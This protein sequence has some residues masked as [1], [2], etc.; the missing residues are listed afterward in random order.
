M[1]TLIQEPITNLFHKWKTHLP[2]T[3]AKHSGSLIC[4]EQIKKVFSTST[5]LQKCKIRALLIGLQAFPMAHSLAHALHCFIPP[6]SSH[7]SIHLCSLALCG[8]S[9]VTVCPSSCGPSCLGQMGSSPPHPPSS[10]MSMR[11]PLN[12]KPRTTG[13]EAYYS[14]WAKT[15]WKKMFLLHSNSGMRCLCNSICEWHAV[16]AVY[17]Y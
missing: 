3:P 15:I 8:E 1:C 17:C 5:L 14:H 4:K 11:G 16:M 10:M 2:M 13:P 12:L 6:S 9:A 7:P